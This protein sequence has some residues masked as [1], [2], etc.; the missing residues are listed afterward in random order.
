MRIV[1]NDICERV[2]FVVHCHLRRAARETSRHKRAHSAIASVEPNAARLMKRECVYCVKIVRSFRSQYGTRAIRRKKHF[3]DISKQWVRSENFF[4]NMED[5]F[6]IHEHVAYFRKALVHSISSVYLTAD[7]TRTNLAH[8][9]IHGVDLLG[10]KLSAE[11]AETVCNWIYSLQ[12]YA[13][14]EDQSRCGFKGWPLLQL[15]GRGEYDEAHVAMTYCALISLVALGDHLSRVRR[16]EIINALR[17]FQQPN[18][19]FSSTASGGECDLRFVYCA[20]AISHILQDWSGIDVCLA[21]AYIHGCFNY[22]GGIGLEPG[23]ESH[24]GAVYCGVAALSL[25]ENLEDALT[26]SERDR[27]IWWLLQRQI[28][29]P[30]SGSSDATCDSGGMQGRPN[31]AA[32]CCYSWFVCASLSLLGYLDCIDRSRLTSFVKKCE[33]AGDQGVEGEG[34]FSKAPEYPP[35]LLHSYFAIAWLSL[36]GEPG[37]EPVDCRLGVSARTADLIANLHFE[38]DPDPT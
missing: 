1:I 5:T 37:L 34:G 22:D 38:S 18:G 15:S 14:E 9:A 28:P 23:L 25:L 10:A 12:V 6:H 17:I 16:R 2:F 33:K 20:C 8:F 31:K 21:K 36:S 24:A 32:C 27:L 4:Y 11:E 35:D 29:Q 7:T 19:S 30:T 26:E 3:F 13:T